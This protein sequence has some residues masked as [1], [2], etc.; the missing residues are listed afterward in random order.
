MHVYLCIGAQMHACINMY[1]ATISSQIVCS[2]VGIQP[3]FQRLVCVC[4]STLVRII[5]FTSHR[6]LILA[7]RFLQAICAIPNIT[8]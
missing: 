6:I 8:V 5:I 7:P 2:G 4:I 1:E 3:A